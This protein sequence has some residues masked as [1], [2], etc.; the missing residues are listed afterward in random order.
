MTRTHTLTALTL[1]LCL[2]PLAAR[3]D[4]SPG[5][6]PVAPPKDPKVAAQLFTEAMINTQ[7]NK[8]LA[9]F[10]EPGAAVMFGKPMKRADAAKLFQQ[11]ANMYKLMHWG[12][13]D[14]SRDAT[15]AEAPKMKKGVMTI[16]TVAY[17]MQ[18]QCAFAKQKSGVWAITA[19]KMINRGSP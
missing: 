18:P 19:C 12:A 6:A 9:L 4:A 16:T 17:G 2:S 1:A 15:P 5:T 7:P 11:P 14:D 8:L 13:P 3:A 10:P